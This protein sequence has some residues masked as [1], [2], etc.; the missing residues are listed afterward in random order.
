MC[1]F[2]ILNNAADWGPLQGSDDPTQE[3]LGA[4]WQNDCEVLL[5]TV[6][7]VGQWNSSGCANAWQSSS[8]LRCGGSRLVKTHSY[9]L[10][11][12][13]ISRGIGLLT[14]T[15]FL[16]FFYLRVDP[17]N[18]IFTPCQRRFFSG[19]PPWTRMG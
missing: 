13:L 18:S 3:Q 4:N 10:H 15:V 9:F 2:N 7:S 19:G 8:R 6:L 11:F 12:F 14:V 5:L 1:L 16:F 17:S